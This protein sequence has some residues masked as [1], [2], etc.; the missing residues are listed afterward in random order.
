MKKFVFFVT[1]SIIFPIILFSAS[2]F[3]EGKELFENNSVE[4]AVYL[5][6]EA[7]ITKP[8]KNVYKYLA[9]C[10]NIL[11]MHEDET[12]VLEEAVSNDVGDSSYFN[13][14]LG[15]AYHLTQDYK[16]SLDSY[17]EVLTLNKGYVNE[18]FL[19]IAN[20]S[21]ELQLYPN[22]IDN[23]TKYLELEPGSTQKRKII[24]MIFILKKL[25]KEHLELLE[26]EKKVNEAVRL[27]KEEELRKL[28]EERLSK[29]A[30]NEKLESD[31]EAKARELEEERMLYASEEQSLLEDRKEFEIAEDKVENPPDP[32]IEEQRRQLQLREDELNER[33]NRILESES[34]L[35]EAEKAL[36]QSRYES[37][38]QTPAEPKIKTEEEILADQR[39]KELEDFTRQKIE[40]EKRQQALM[41]DIL[42]SLEKIGE[43]A[44]GINA[45]SEGAFGELEGSDID[46]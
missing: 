15:N 36:E 8:S 34:A 23:Y 19:N 24:K 10:Y 30:F 1:I 38:V 27:A 22:A 9:E 2:A 28:E 31:R 17:L 14:K 41:N 45:E 33:E 40:E 18:S 25:Q 29:S 13:F 42:Q 12:L 39:E 37:E 21:V 35:K 20:V 32:D 7:L 3:Q 44:K 4:E 6:E 43:N 5:F 26:E 46:E 11:G 16:N